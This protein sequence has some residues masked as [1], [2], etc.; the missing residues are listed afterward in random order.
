MK[1]EKLLNEFLECERT[2][3]MNDYHSPYFNNKLKMIKEVILERM[4]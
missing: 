1:S 4:K 2:L 3:A